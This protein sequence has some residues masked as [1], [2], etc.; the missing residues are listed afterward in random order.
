LPRKSAFKLRK[1]PVQLGQAIYIVLLIVAAAAL[2]LAI[3]F[4]TV[5]YISSYKGAAA[6]GSPDKIITAADL[7]IPP[8][9][10]KKVAAPEG[11][12]EAAKPAD[13]ASAPTDAGATK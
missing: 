4:P 7:Q 12:A 9:T 2:V 10:T 1:S 11:G 6:A 5:E 3:T 13:G 8:D